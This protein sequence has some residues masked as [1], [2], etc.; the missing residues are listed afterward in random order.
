MRTA[1][2]VG[3]MLVEDCKMKNCES[4]QQ[5]ACELAGGRRISN[6]NA[7]LTWKCCPTRQPPTYRRVPDDHLVASLGGRCEE[8]LLVLLTLVVA[9]SV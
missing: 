5:G 1:L 6:F 9:L 2:F 4:D 8:K 3:A 7:P